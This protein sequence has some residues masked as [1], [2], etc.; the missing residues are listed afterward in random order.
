MSLLIEKLKAKGPKRILA[1]DGGGLRGIV[2]LAY[3]KK[4]EEDLRSLHKNPDLR[5][6]DY[7]DLIGGTS[8]GSIIATGLALGMT[9]SE[10]EAHYLT[11][12][13]KIFGKKKGLIQYLTHSE[14]FDAKPLTNA[15]KATFG[16]V[17]LGDQEKV[18]TGL[19]IITKRADT[20]S[21][22]PFHNHPDGK[23]YNENCQLPIYQLVRASAAAPTYFVPVM[24][25]IGED[26]N[27]AFID[28]GIS[29]ANNPSL[30]LL[31]LATLRGYPFHWPIGEDKLQL[32]SIGTGHLSREYDTKKF[33]SVNILQWANMLPEFFMT[34]ANYYNQIIMQ[35]L[36]DSPTAKIIDSEI[37][38]LKN[39]MMVRNN[40]LS[41]LRYDLS[42][43]SRNLNKLGFDLTEKEILEL[44]KIDEPKNLSKLSEIGAA[45][46]AVQIKKSHLNKTFFLNETHEKQKLRITQNSKMPEGAIEVIKK[47]IPIEAIQINEPFEVETIEGLM[48]GKQ[49]DFLMRGVNGEYYVCDKNIFNQTYESIKK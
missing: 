18:K 3:L 17:Q 35:I 21:T 41:Y 4:L 16:E 31:M 12:G 45:S 7:F 10:L 15:L 22:W 39:D 27:G 28:G 34:D 38:T 11:L 8:T 46:A 48:K 47:Q 6:S 14:K 33:K 37:G 40:V 9:V 13:G 23:F 44:S 32:I 1:L 43:D 24:I 30:T 2:A 49:G 42:L 29:M 26:L 25:K 5:L 20:F 36:S 19:C